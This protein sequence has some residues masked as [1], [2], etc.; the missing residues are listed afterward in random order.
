MPQRSR[1]RL[2]FPF[3]IAIV[4]VWTAAT[5]ASML[6]GD[7]QPLVITTPVM[8]MAASFVFSIRRNGKNGA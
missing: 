4:V 1:E 8:L 7:Y 2:I 5:I 3:A 6:T